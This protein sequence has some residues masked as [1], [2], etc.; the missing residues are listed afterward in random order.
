MITVSQINAL[1]HEI[2]KLSSSL[3][4]SVPNG[5]QKDKI[6]R[7]MSGPEGDNVF[8]TFNKRFDALFAEDA[9][10]R[11]SDGRF[12][13]LCKGNYGMDAVT[14]YL[15]QVDWSSGV[16]LDLVEI[17]L[18]RLVLELR[19]L[20]NRYVCDSLSTTLLTNSWWANS[21]TQSRPSRQINPTAKLRDN[22]NSE[23]AAVSFQRKAVH[24]FRARHDLPLST[25]SLL[26]AD[27]DTELS[28]PIAPVDKPSPSP[29][30]STI[31][32]SLPSQLPKRAVSFV[33]S[34]DD[35]ADDVQ[36]K[37]REWNLFYHCQRY[38]CF[39]KRR[40]RANLH[41][42]TQMHLEPMD[43]LKTSTSNR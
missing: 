25:T 38:S 17:K 8:E 36:P 10:C 9:H 31:T 26:P 7:L 21:K 27:A 14:S 29:L 13:F 35:E 1:I 40:R 20:T 42:R 5:T 23:Q 30:T 28:T 2:T 37:R 11:N 32:S 43:C 15:S 24:D 3:P 19:H 16:P 18:N 41:S 22:N 6:W 4:A 39:L 33:T 34:S 12:H